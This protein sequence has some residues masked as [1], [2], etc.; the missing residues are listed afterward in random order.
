MKAGAAAEG[1]QKTW[2][3]DKTKSK[4]VFY[5]IREVSWFNGATTSYTVE[6]AGAPGD[7][8]DDDATMNPET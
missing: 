1:G 6:T 4:D 8:H 2:S 5:Q 7:Y 3:V